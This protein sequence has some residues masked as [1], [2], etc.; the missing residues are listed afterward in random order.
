MKFILGQIKLN[1]IHISKKLKHQ[2]LIDYYGFSDVV[3][4]QIHVLIMEYSHFG[5][6][7]H[8][9]K[10]VIKRAY[11]SESLIGIFVVQIFKRSILYSYYL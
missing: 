1:E 2:H 3:K 4:D 9:R 8:F 10:N 6:M 11:F 5:N 7:K